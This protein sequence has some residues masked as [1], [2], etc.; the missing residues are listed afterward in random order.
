[1]TTTNEHGNSFA[2]GAWVVHTDLG[3]GEITAIETKSIGNKKSDYYRLNITD[4]NSTVWV[5]IGAEGMLREVTPTREFAKVVA[6]LKRPSRLMSSSFQTRLAR[7][8]KAKAK[9]TPQALA[10]IIRDLWSRKARRG[11]LSTTEK[12]ELR[13]M[14][15][16]LLAEWSVSVRKDES[17]VSEKLYTLLRQTAQLKARV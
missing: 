12:W 10:R 13:D 17:K 16:Q 5:P 11:K 2:S 4:S 15:E 3:I 1:M 7:I 8:R 6:V 9:G 14:I